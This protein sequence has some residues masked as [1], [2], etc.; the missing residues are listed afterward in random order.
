MSGAGGVGKTTLLQEF[1]RIADEAGRNVARLDGREYRASAAG[2]LAA[3]SPVPGAEHANVPAVMER[4]P[5]GS[6]LLVDTYELLVS[7][8]DWLRQTLLPQFPAR[9]LVVIAG[10]TR[11]P[12][13]GGPMSHGRR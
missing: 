6:V 1:A 13:R 5:A 7:L 4:W 3:L 12:R 2:V 9:S 10:R 11:Q 8:D